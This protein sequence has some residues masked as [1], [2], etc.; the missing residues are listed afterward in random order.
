DMK[1]AVITPCSHFFH[2]AC[3]KKWLYV[4]ETCPLCHGQ[5]KS[6]LQPT[7]SPG[8]AP[9]GTPPANQNPVEE[10]QE[11]GEPQV[12]LDTEE[13]TEAKNTLPVKTSAE[14]ELEAALL[15]GS[16]K[17]QPKECDVTAESSADPPGDL[18]GDGS[19]ST[20]DVHSSS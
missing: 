1:S 17:I 6:Q 13:D 12:E 5:L 7:S 15:S 9:Q 19:C 2:A 16:S 18:D 8:A 14:P 11:Q 3:L 10:E 4:Q 20:S